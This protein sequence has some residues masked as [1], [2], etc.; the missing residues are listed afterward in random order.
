MESDSGQKRI[1][2]GLAGAIE[3]MELVMKYL[4]IKDVSEQLRIKPATI[5][6][7]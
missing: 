4:T 1:A 6:G 2:A 7:W 3:D 5:Y